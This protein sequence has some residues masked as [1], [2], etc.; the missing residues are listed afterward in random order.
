MNDR[1]ELRLVVA[2]TAEAC[3]SEDGLRH[4]AQTFLCPE[5]SNRAEL[6]RI[7]RRGRLACVELRDY[8]EASNDG[9]GVP[10]KRPSG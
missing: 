9:D 3:S 8:I 4:E 2:T 7:W 10:A 6:L 1:I 5:F